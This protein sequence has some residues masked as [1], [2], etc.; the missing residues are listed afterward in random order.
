MGRKLWGTGGVPGFWSGDIW[1]SHNSQFLFDP[2]T[3]THITQGI[4]FY[5]LLAL[6]LSKSPLLFRL[7]LTVG[8]ESIWEI[9][10]N[11]RL[12]IERYRAETIA[13]NYYGD[14]VLNSMCDLVACMFGFYLASRFP[15]RVTVL[16]V[17]AAEIVL[18]FWT[19]DNFALN[20]LMLIHP[21]PGIRA[22]QSVR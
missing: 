6:L 9:L 2:Y 7:V 18:L 16:F 19:R 4:L 15:T 12:V 8:L 14:S 22:W 10:E 21:V 11:S 3:L 20:V 5:A 13:L 17:V 1:S